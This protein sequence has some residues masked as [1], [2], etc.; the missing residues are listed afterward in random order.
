M[1]DGTSTSKAPAEFFAPVFSEASTEQQKVIL[2]ALKSPEQAKELLAGLLLPLVIP[3][4]PTH[5]GP[6]V[7]M[8]LQLDNTEI[9]KLIQSPPLLTS[10]VAEAME[11]LASKPP[12][13][14][15]T[16][17]SSRNVRFAA[18]PPT[19]SPLSSSKALAPPP[20]LGHE[21]EISR[22][23]Y[24]DAT[25]T[26]ESRFQA[27]TDAATRDSGPCR[28]STEGDLRSRTFGQAPS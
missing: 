19:E 14:G 17:A 7:S 27:E 15:N 21:T 11:D 6:V 24:A 13:Q 26:L 2:T 5:A 3:L 25:R 18:V 20:G 8:F 12:S 10:K 23:S 9:W 4:E 28:G 16:S 22:E 1:A